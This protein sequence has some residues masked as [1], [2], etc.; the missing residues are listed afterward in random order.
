MKLLVTGGAGFTPHQPNHMKMT[1]SK[2]FF[3][4]LLLDFKIKLL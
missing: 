4:F 3:K 1:I 2:S